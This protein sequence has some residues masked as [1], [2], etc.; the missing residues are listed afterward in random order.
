VQLLVVVQLEHLRRDAD[1]DRIGLALVGIYDHAE[2][3]HG[4]K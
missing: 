4:E 2:V 1:A 3:A